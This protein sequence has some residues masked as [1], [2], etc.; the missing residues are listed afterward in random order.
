MVY[1]LP[2]YH[3]MRLIEEVCMLD[4][5]S[6]GRFELGVGRGVSPLESNAYAVDFQKSGKQYHEAFQLLMKGLS[7]D[8]LDFEGEFYKFSDIPMIVKPMQ[9]PHPPLWYGLVFP[10]QA[11]WPAANDVNIITLGMSD[12]I[13]AVV[14][15]YHAERAKLGKD[16]K[17]S[18]LVG[19]T[20]HVVVAKTD[21]EAM[22][23]ARRTYVKW[24]N[25]F[26]WLWER[27]KADPHIRHIYPSTFD[28]L[29]RSATVSPVRRRR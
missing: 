6:G 15:R 1:L 27:H 12:G 2:F 4:Q 11:T 29:V 24:E 3:P 22:K 9:K 17:T 13:R 28:E 21:D 16:R 7:V 23:I 25:S 10:D 20:R 14:D 19:V 26:Y 18:P 5:M 8:V